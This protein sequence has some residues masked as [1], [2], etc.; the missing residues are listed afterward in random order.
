VNPDQYFVRAWLRNGDVLETETRFI[1]VF[2]QCSHVVA[3]ITVATAENPG[4]CHD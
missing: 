1:R 3:G 4:M 2:D